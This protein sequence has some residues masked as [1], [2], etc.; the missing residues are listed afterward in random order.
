M[1]IKVPMD[2]PRL[3][4]RVLQV[5]IDTAVRASELSLIA[6][7]LSLTW[8]VAKFANIAH[9]QYA[10]LAAYLA[11]MFVQVFT[12]SLVLGVAAAI[13]ATGVISV[14]L[15]QL[16]FRR[17]VR[18]S[19]STALIGSLAI[20]I[21]ITAGIQT[22]V[23]PRPYRLPVPIEPGLRFGEALVT[24]TQLY[25]VVI[26][27][28]VLIAFFAG[29]MLTQV[30]R[31]IRCVMAN[32]ELAEASGINADRIRLHVFFV[33]GALAA[34][35]GILLALD[36]TVSLDMGAALL[37]PV[38]AAVIMGGVGSPLGSVVAAAV[39]AFAENLVLAVDFGELLGGESRYVPLNYSA[40]IGFIALILVM[41]LRPQGIFGFGGRRA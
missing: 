37:L 32:A 39:L 27:S 40:A 24:R 21:V 11:L 34:L 2:H 18:A 9:V 19:G 17:L 6:I 10:P 13:V 35:G 1:G 33:S 7:G 5:L 22:I 14:L 29:L 8:G 3:G 36:T 41:L 31:S 16:F 20:S 30:G 26:V 38:V 25:I 4:V 23:G 12:F 28:V 15:Y